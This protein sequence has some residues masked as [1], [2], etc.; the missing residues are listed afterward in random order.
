MPGRSI[1]AADV[2]A[3]GLDDL[4]WVNE[5]GTQVYVFTARPNLVANEDGRGT[6]GQ[7]SP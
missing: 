4:L 6:S 3:D 1:T 2:D 7:V 5:N